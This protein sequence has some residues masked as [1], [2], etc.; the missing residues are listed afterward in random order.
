M[1]NVYEIKPVK[2]R[3]TSEPEHGDG[4]ANV[5][6]YYRAHFHDA[7][8]RYLEAPKGLETVEMKLL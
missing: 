1:L 7:W 3:I 6:G 4:E 8:K 5:R 2:M